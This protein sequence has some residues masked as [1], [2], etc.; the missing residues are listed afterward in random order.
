L[1]ALITEMNASVMWFMRAAYRAHEPVM[2]EMA[3]DGSDWGRT[4]GAADSADRIGD[5]QVAVGLLNEAREFD[6]EGYA[7]GL[8]RIRIKPD[9]DKWHSYYDFG[10]DEIVTEGKFWRQPAAERLHM[11]LHEIGHRGQAVDRHTWEEFKRRH[12]A[13]MR[14]FR[15]MANPV[16]LR[17]ER[18]GHL[19]NLAEEVFAESYARWCLGL[20]MPDE[21]R[22]FWDG[23]G[24]YGGADLRNG[25]RGAGADARYSC[26]RI[27]L[28]GV[29][30]N[31][32][33]G[34]DNNGDLGRVRNFSLSCDTGEMALD[35][36]PAEHLRKAFAKLRK[37]WLRNID[38]AAPKLARW[39]AQS[40]ARR[41]DG[42]LAR[43]LRDGGFSVKMQHT[44]ATRDIL[45][46]SVA[47][48]VALI[49]SIPQQYLTQVEGIVMRSVQTGRDLEQLT[50]DLRAQFG[51]TKRRAAFIALD[52]NNKATAAMTRARQMEFG[53]KAIWRHS[54]AGKKPRPTH[55]AND[56]QPYDPVEG[57]F[58]PHERKRIWPGTLI[59]C[60]PG[61]TA[62]EFAYQTKK[63]FRHWYSGQLTEV[64]TD[65]GKALAATPNH[66]VLTSTGWRSIGSLNEGDCL[67][68]IPAQ[69]SNIAMM[70]GHVDH[71]I[72]GIG[73]IFDTLVKTGIRRSEISVGNEFHGDIGAHGNI[74]VIFTARPLMIGRKALISQRRQHVEFPVADDATLESCAGYQFMLA[75]A[76]PPHL[77]MCSTREMGAA[78]DTLAV[79]SD[80][81]G[82]ASPARL[83][84]CEDNSS[85]YG[86]AVNTMLLGECKYTFPCFMF[87]TKKARIVNIRRSKFDGH[88]YNL[89]TGVG[90][91]VA[92]GIIVH[93]CRCYSQT[94]VPGFS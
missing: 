36:S 80:E 37:R 65:T 69:G 49:K 11:M 71:A 6:R 57:W 52:Q 91:Y 51:V 67:I 87:G 35:A 59:N 46:A 42:V 45:E 72:S 84:P 63:A 4:L 39:F 83:T 48:N 30:L 64:I 9:R 2:T 47:E 33:H 79:H 34:C 10:R 17:D 60:F 13:T 19:H 14:S 20:P 70:E 77:V 16:H 24:N 27:G 66:P 38:E 89:Q 26:D 75:P 21:L 15:L 44:P 56:R 8:R 18:E 1:N 93:N 31:G 22:G 23:R 58:D 40:A 41:S 53:L 25:G 68:E 54:H 76:Y 81:I 61:S 85:H 12:E 88:V 43:I 94:Q 5:D 92:G 82:S 7:F 86:P 50:R 62:I 74:D 78:F 29:D 73:Q 32:N 3:N 55:V 28:D 90:W